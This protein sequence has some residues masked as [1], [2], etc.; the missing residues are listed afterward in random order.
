[1][2]KRTARYLVFTDL[3]GTLLDHHDYSY[4]AAKPVLEMLV[5]RDIPLIMCTSKTRSEMEA[6][7]ADMHRYEPFIVE[8]GGAIFFP[9]DY[10]RFTINDSMIMH[11]YKCIPLGVPYACIR[12]FVREVR[13]MYAIRGFG[14]MSTEE[15][16]ERTGLPME[17]VV[18]AKTREFTEPF[19]IEDEKHIPEL[20]RKA[21]RQGLRITRG[22]RFFHFIGEHND[23]GLA[24]KTAKAIYT[25][26]WRITPTTIGLGDSPNDFPMLAVVDYPVLIP[27][28]DGRYEDIILPRLTLAKSP[29]SKGWNDALG[30]ILNNMHV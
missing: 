18:M 21:K 16:A 7:Q 10:E 20:S 26:N 28:P 19:V 5:Q 17:R 25:E 4:T 11:G 8:N 2:K 9:Q 24:V 27:H 13:D 23:K 30:N 29:G 3:D 12:A 15:I 1:M 6:I 22:G 14:D